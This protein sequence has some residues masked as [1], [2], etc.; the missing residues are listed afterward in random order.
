MKMRSRENISDMFEQEYPIEAGSMGEPSGHDGAAG[1]YDNEGDPQYY[2]QDSYDEFTDEENQLDEQQYENVPGSFH[3][4]YQTAGSAHHRAPYDED[5][6]SHSGD[7]DQRP[8]DFSDNPRRRLSAQGASLGSS[9]NGTFPVTDN[10]SPTA[11][12]VMDHGPAGPSHFNQL[13]NDGPERRIIVVRLKKEPEVGIGII[14]VGGENTGQLDLGIFVK[15]VTPGGPAERDG[16]VQPG[17]RIIAIDG[18]SLE[19]M[20]HHVAVELIRKASDSVELM[21]S[22]TKTSQFHLRESTPTPDV[23]SRVDTMQADKTYR[24]S[25]RPQRAPPSPPTR[26]GDGREASDNESETTLTDTGMLS[27]SELNSGRPP[28]A[29]LPV[30]EDADISDLELEDVLPP[31]AMRPD[32]AQQHMS[33][34]SILSLKLPMMTVAKFQSGD[35]AKTVITGTKVGQ[36]LTPADDRSSTHLQKADSP[37]ELRSDHEEL[38][39]T[40]DT[41]FEDSLQRE[42]VSGR[43]GSPEV[44]EILSRTSQQSSLRSQ[45]APLT[46]LKPGDK[47]EVVLQKK[48]GSLGLNVTGGKNT[49]VKLGGIYVKSFARDGPAEADGRIQI[50]DRVLEVNKKSLNGVTHREAVEALRGAPNVCKLLFERGVPVIPKPG[51]MSPSQQSESTM[52]RDMTPS[53]APSSVVDMETGYSF[54]TPGN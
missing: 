42:T 54:V 36:R 35:S 51:A 45:S 8:S 13:S 6:M 30:P 10:V 29:I 5:G 15:S 38:P 24:S 48:L 49:S 17:D 23:A 20:P 3:K 2:E 43:P 39:V 53:T 25:S 7:S 4:H 32:Y 33:P 19:G 40:S 31:E 27:I 34:T 22:Q 28:K 41:E 21:V 14:I 44:Q 1:D 47:Y 16:R 50:G 46:Q 9:L 18:Q 52:S 12:L 11:M 26:K 37:I